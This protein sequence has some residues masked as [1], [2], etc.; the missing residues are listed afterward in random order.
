[1]D[2]HNFIEF[3]STGRVR[4][5]EPMSG[6]PISNKSV[7]LRLLRSFTGEWTEWLPIGVFLIRHAKGP[8]LVDTGASSQC[9]KAGYFPTLSYFATVLNQLEI[10]TEDDIINQLAKNGV[11]PTD[12]QAIVLTHLHHDHA[13]GL[14]DIMKA[15]PHVPVY[16]DPNHWEAFGKH[17]T[18]A[19]FQ[20]CAPNHWPKD[21]SPKM[22]QFEDKPVGPWTESAS[23]TEDGQIIAVQTPGHVPG[24]VSLLVTEGSGDSSMNTTYL[25]TGDATYS[26]ELLEKEEPDGI[27]NDPQTAFKSLQLIKEFAR[28]RDVVVIPSHDPNSSEILRSKKIYK[29]L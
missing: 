27:N 21:F 2:N 16:V 8:I 4:M 12:L 9:M 19:A 28:Q 13:G 29:P 17:P 5:R 24:H 20:G 11:K 23:V 25:L 18:Y 14:E 10:S 1:M 26:L 6:Q 3:I 15:A 7:T 22:L